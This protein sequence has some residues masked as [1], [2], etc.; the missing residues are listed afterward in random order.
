[1]PLTDEFF[2][3]FYRGNAAEQIVSSQ[4]FI[5]GF[6]AHKFN[7]DFG[8]D[9]LVTNKAR[10][11]FL[12][13]TP[14]EIN[15]QVKSSL[16]VKNRASIKIKKEELEHLLEH[17]NPVLVSVLFEPEFIGNP[18]QREYLDSYAQTIHD[19]DEW[20]DKSWAE[21]Q[22]HSQFDTLKSH[23]KEQYLKN[24]RAANNLELDGYK[25]SL[26]WLNKNQL[27]TALEAGIL[28]D[29]KGNGKD[30]YYLNFNKEESEYW[31]FI[32]DKNDVYFPLIEITYLSYLLLNRSNY[33]LDMENFAHDF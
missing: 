23:D 29:G 32:S 2:E 18:S 28:Q 24:R 14:K 30:N 8:V 31:Q 16:V 5:H 17:D 13:E 27:K 20:L 4:V 22:Y 6:E 11:K 15:I 12:S 33:G 9:L 3:N 26:F 25:S 21:Q 1:M 19:M 7:P 10:Q